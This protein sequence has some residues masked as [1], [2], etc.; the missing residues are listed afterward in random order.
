MKTPRFLARAQ[1]GFTLIELLVV[2]TIIAVLAAML[3]PAIRMI[4]ES[5]NKMVCASNLRQLG[6]GSTLYANDNEGMVPP[7]Q[8]PSGAAGEF[9][10]FARIAGY[11]IDH[12]TGR[13]WLPGATLSQKELDISKIFS[14]KNAGFSRQDIINTGLVDRILNGSYAINKRLDTAIFGR[15]MGVGPDAAPYLRPI[16]MAT[17][18]SQIILMTEV[19]AVGSGGGIPVPQRILYVEEPY[20]NSGIPQYSI[21]SSTPRRTI[22]T[23]LGAGRTQASLRQSHSGGQANYIF[24][25]LHVGAMRDV[26]TFFN[27]LGA[28]T[29]PVNMWRGIIR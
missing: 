18:S 29:K 7:T 3:M 26:D 28:Q 24:L 14:C 17:G 15:D 10:F 1:M 8:D 5:A 19:W 21:P 16:G 27:G 22:P 9:T 4:R 25:D 13:M 2:I 11:T 12:Y 20:T 23:T 6:I